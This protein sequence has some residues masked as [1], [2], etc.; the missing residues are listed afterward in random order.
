MLSVLAVNWAFLILRCA[1][2]MLF[3]FIALAW[4]GLTSM[5]LVMLFGGYAL[6]DG[7]L[8]LI[9]A[10][11]ANGVPGFGS[12]LLEALVRIAVGVFAFA[13]PGA[14]ALAMPTVFAVY[15]VA[16]G[17]TAIAVAVA[18]R[19]DLTGDWPLPLAG[20]VSILFGVLLWAG[21]ARA[22]TMDWVFGPYAFLFGLTLL[23]LA[24]RLRQLAAEI[25]ASSP[26]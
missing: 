10:I 1:I 13:A 24:L 6:T 25:A 3:G 19:R 11:S 21:P 22:T 23:T 20:A 14:T 15:A 8:A 7:A 26:L 12:L 9:V 2:A 16:S 18:L 17:L 4:P 5:G